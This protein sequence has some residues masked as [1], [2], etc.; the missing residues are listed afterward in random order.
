METFIQ[1]IIAYD[2]KTREQ[3]DFAHR[4]L[5]Q[6]THDG[7]L[8]QQNMYDRYVEKETKELQAYQ[9]Q[10]EQEY[11]SL[12]QQYQAKIQKLHQ[13]Q[14]KLEQQNQNRAKEIVQQMIQ[15][16]KDEQQ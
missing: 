10:L 3:V 14:N 16:L 1:E 13:Q 11:L 12:E 7:K 2:K 4:Q 8:E 9:Q 15:K 6:T 5:Q